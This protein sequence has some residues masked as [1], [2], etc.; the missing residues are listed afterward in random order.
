MLKF[1]VRKAADSSENIKADIPGFTPQRVPKIPNFGPKT[2]FHGSEVQGGNFDQAFVFIENEWD[3]V[4]D[5]NGKQ[6]YFPRKGMRKTAI[7]WG[8]LKLFTTELQF[9]NKYWD[10]KQVPNPLVVYVGAAPGVH[11]GFLAKMFPQ[12]T[13]HLY[14]AR[15]FDVS[16][17]DIPNVKTFVQFFTNE[18]A[19]QYSKR[20]DVL[21]ISDI[22][23]LEYN[24]DLEQ[25]EEVQRK[26]EGI[27]DSDMKMQMDWVKIINPVKSHLKFRL[28][29][30]YPWNKEKYYSYLDGD[31]YK[32]PWA[33]QTSTETRLVVDN[34]SS[35]KQWNTSVYEQFLFYHN[36]VVRE[37]VKFVNPLTNINEPISLEL[38]LLQDYDSV[39]FAVTVRE[40]L[41]KFSD[42]KEN[43]DAVKVLLLCKAII[44]SVGQNTVNIVNIRA[45]S[46]GELNEV[47]RLNLQK[48]LRSMGDEEEDEE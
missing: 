43:I 37:H 40:Y 6:E 22:R 5:G 4:G 27:A 48:T 31:V 44:S 13:F 20:N 9:L 12:I 11:T 26:N 1:G 46:K 33:P 17:K 39:V 38:G 28:P 10:Y 45:G 19:S 30:Q 32:Q 18:T 2:V 3:T 21:F 35:I 24:K 36:N 14:D 7:K 34:S 41:Q 42:N 25:T 16:L 23:T 15:Q 8:Q 29:Y 47:A